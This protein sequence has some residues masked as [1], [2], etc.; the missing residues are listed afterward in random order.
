MNPLTK[1]FHAIND[2]TLSAKLYKFINRHR[3]FFYLEDD[4][5][6]TAQISS[7]VYKK[8]KK[9]YRDVLSKEIPLMERKHNDTVW[10]CWF[11][12]I[13]NAPLLCQ[14]CVDRIKDVYGEK[15]VVVIT[16]ENFREYTHI[17]DYI[18]KKWEKGIITNTHFSDILRVAL[19]SE[20][21]GTWIDA[22]ILI[23]KKDLPKYFY[24]SRLFLL[25]ITSA[26]SIPISRVPI[27]AL[28]PAAGL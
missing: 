1:F 20:N 14:A 18:I 11:Q 4:N 6:R 27:S 25:R 19:L 13:E 3:H 5:L 7:M 9:D 12:G 8:L 26:V 17:P 2:G 15:N 24:D 22:T 10:V 23:L 28:I 21:G 16:G